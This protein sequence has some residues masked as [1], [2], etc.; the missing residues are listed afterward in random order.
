MLVVRRSIIGPSGLHQLWS[1]AAQ[2]QQLLPSHM[3]MHIYWLPQVFRTLRAG[4]YT[5][6]LAF[7]PESEFL[8]SVSAEG[9]LQVWDMADGKVKYAQK[10]VAPKVAFCYRV[11]LCKYVTWLIAFH[12]DAV[13][14]SASPCS[15]TYNIMMLQNSR[16]GAICCYECMAV[17]AGG[18]A[19]YAQRVLT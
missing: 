8:A 3:S 16:A 6:S 2:Q 5:R 9:T 7:D 19:L 14:H 12:H 15:C 17:N 13:K 4:P 18:P 10:R 11:A 1:H